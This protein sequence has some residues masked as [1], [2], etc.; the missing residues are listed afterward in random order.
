MITHNTSRFGKCKMAAIGREQ[1][2]SGN[3]ATTV[4]LLEVL[5]LIFMFAHTIRFG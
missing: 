1:A 2:M 5:S 4:G 3:V